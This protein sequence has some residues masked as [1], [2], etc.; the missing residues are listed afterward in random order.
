MEL[1]QLRYFCVVA[2]YENM[3]RAAEELYVAQS[4]LSKTIKKLETELGV[5]LFNR[6][7]KRLYLNKFG[8][9]FY[10]NVSISLQKLDNAVKELRDSSEDVTGV[11]TIM[12]KAAIN[13]IPQLLKEFKKKCPLVT[14]RVLTPFYD[15][16]CK[17]RQDFDIVIFG[18]PDEYDSPYKIPLM[19][20]EEIVLMVPKGHPLAGRGAINLAEAAPYPFVA[21]SKSSSIDR[22]FASM[23]ENAGF[24]PAILFESD[25]DMIHAELASAGLG[26]S[27]VPLKTMS[28]M[29]LDGVEIVKLNS[30]YN[31]RDIWLAWNNARYMSKAVK[32]LM[33]HYVDFFAILEHVGLERYCRKNIL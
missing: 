12:V 23:C 26:I 7:G 31:K 27:L 32:A 1:L 29:F 4:S 15:I 21:Y 16:E 6:V 18:T 14:V 5:P 11:V 24:T 3:T 25:N 17:E 9:N 28:F 13:T 19:K 8:K 30:I 33:D 2:Q 20:N 10:Q 22:L